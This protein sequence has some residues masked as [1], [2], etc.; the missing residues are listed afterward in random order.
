MTMI[1]IEPYQAP[2][3]TVREQME[4][5][6]PGADDGG[7]PPK[8]YLRGPPKSAYRTEDR[9]QAERHVRAREIHL[10]RREEQRSARGA[11]EQ[12]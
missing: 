11:G 1:R 9:E 10:W 3:S 4:G 6:P 12:Q 2:R 7:I 8:G 5:R